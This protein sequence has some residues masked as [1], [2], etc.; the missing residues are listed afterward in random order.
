MKLDAT[1]A[2]LGGTAVGCVKFLGLASILDWPDENNNGKEPSKLPSKS[3][4][5]KL[6]L[7]FERATQGDVLKF[8]SGQLT[9]SPFIS[10]WDQVASALSSIASGINSLHEHGV[11][12]R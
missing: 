9:D 3:K 4:T 12:H 2:S 5:R 6:L 10:G 7:V 11:L 1:Y 8:L